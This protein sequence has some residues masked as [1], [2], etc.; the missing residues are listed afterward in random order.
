MPTASA[1]VRQRV[2]KL[3]A[4]IERHNY[5]YFVLDDPEISDAEFDRMIERSVFDSKR[6]ASS[7]IRPCRKPMVT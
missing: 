5:R 2:K 3:R 1:S 4:E 6:R 7:G